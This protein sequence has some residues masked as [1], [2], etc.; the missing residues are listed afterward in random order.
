MRRA[1]TDSDK[2][3]PDDGTV[4]AVM[5]ITHNNAA[6]IKGLTEY[7]AKHSAGGPK[8][9]AG[10]WLEWRSTAANTARVRICDKIKAELGNVK[11]G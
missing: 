2:I 8:G 7:S 3:M 4:E 6:N 11:I 1:G 10:N 5:T 9:I